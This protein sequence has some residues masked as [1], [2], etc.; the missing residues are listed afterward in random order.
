[1]RPNY[2]LVAE[3]VATVRARRAVNRKAAAWY[4]R[5]PMRRLL[6]RPQR[7]GLSR[8]FSLAEICRSA[9]GNRLHFADAPLCATDANY[10]AGHPSALG[11][12]TCGC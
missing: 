12:A 7:G 1:L 11:R 2:L 4:N 10:P 8:W 6:Q 3:T 5:P 9:S